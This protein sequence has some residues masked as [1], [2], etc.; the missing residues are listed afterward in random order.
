M[1]KV[2]QYKRLL[3]IPLNDQSMWNIINQGLVVITKPLKILIGP[4][5]SQ[6]GDAQR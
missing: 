6:V 4:A 3:N 2:Y 1:C 5:T